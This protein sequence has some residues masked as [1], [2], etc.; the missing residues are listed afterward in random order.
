MYSYNS[1]ELIGLYTLLCQKPNRKYYIML[2]STGVGRIANDTELRNVTRTDGTPTQVITISVAADVG[3]G[4][5]DTSFVR[6]ELWGKRAVA[7]AKHLVVGQVV[8]FSGE[9][10]V[11]DFIRGEHS[12]YAGSTGTSNTIKNVS[13]FA[14][15][16]KPINGGRPMVPALYSAS[17]GTVVTSLDQL[18]TP[19]N[20][21]V[22]SPVEAPAAPEMDGDPFDITVD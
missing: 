4:G 17:P 19:T 3:Q 14:W 21:K 13:T 5:V 10:Y 7:A 15:G 20:Q 2:I 1:S 22:T 11:E 9:T 12:A 16:A 18:P 8:N 6:V